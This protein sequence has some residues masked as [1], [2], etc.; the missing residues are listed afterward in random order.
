[1][2]TPAE[3]FIA[4]YASEYYDPVKAKEYYERT[5]QLK[6][7]QST[8]GMS[9]T[10]RQA[11]SYTKS[12]IG[13]A[14]K[15]DL[16]KAQAIQKAQLEAVRKT[17]EAR[18]A[19]ISAKL[20]SILENIAA[21]AAEQEAVVM[22]KVKQLPLNKIPSNASPKQRAFLL[23]QNA[24]IRTSNKKA[25]DAAASAFAV[26]RQ[27]AQ[28]LKSDASVSARKAAQKA[29]G[30]EMRRVGAEAKGAVAKARSSYMATRKQVEAKYDAATDKEYQ[31][32]R[33]QL[34]SAPPKVKKPRAST[35]RKR[36]TTKKE[37]DLQNDSETRL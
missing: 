15:A 19:Q 10:Q 23:Q 36:Q 16:T 5:K 29:A 21:K 13:E 22:P 33:T 37:G 34:P 8:K 14:K 27:A 20:K 3:E 17:A 9:D 30:E 28:K 25:F 18:R 12:R 32:I 31:N 1:M 26:K 4:H 35:R 11:L 2:P 24:S 7:R 6:G